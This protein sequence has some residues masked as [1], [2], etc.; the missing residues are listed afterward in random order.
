MPLVSRFLIRTALLQFAVGATIGSLMLA[1][2]GLRVAPWLWT[3]RPAHIQMML[4]GW[5]VQLA[6]GVAIWILPRLDA[7]GGRGNLGL[8]WLG[9][10]AL[11]AGV[12]LAA[13]QLPLAGLLGQG[14]LGWMPPLAGLLYLVALAAMVAHLWRRVLPFR[15]LPRPRRPGEG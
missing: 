2:K 6:C 11:N 8:A 10:G 12:A 1:E 14:R 7:A 5:T 9:Y 4:L 15:S 3:L 13:L